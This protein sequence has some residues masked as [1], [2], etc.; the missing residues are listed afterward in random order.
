MTSRSRTLLEKASSTP[1]LRRFRDEADRASDAANS[2]D[3]SLQRYEHMLAEE[4]ELCAV[5]SDLLRA[6]CW[7]TSGWRQF[8]PS[9]RT[10]ST[11]TQ[12]GSRWGCMQLSDHWHPDA[13]PLAMNDPRANIRYAGNLLHW[14]H[15]QSGSWERATI[16]FFGHDARA[17]N[18]ARRVERYRQERPWTARLS[19]RPSTHD[20]ANA[21]P[22]SDD[23]LYADLA[24]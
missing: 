6:I 12:Y 2:S 21:T 18:A 24:L 7:Y 17:E 8:E 4:A 1:L 23:S 15:E 3:E 14:L 19:C 5:P 11:P 16:A 22:I 9:G 13:F 10:L 20:N